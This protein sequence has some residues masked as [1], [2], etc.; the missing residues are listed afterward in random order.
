MTVVNEYLTVKQV[1]ERLQICLSSAYQLV[2]SGELP[3]INVSNGRK[4]PRIR[5]RSS[6]VEAF[7]DRREQGRAA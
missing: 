6:A 2:Y 3:R 1:A 7:A 5:V 4:K